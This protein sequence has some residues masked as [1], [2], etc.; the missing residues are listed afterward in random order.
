MSNKSTV[1]F[2]VMCSM[3][4]AAQAGFSTPENSVVKS[5][6]AGGEK[7]KSTNGGKAPATSA[8]PPA[9]ENGVKMGTQPRWK[10]YFISTNEYADYLHKDYAYVSEVK[11]PEELDTAVQN[12]FK[13]AYRN[14]Y[15]ALNLSTKDEDQIYDIVDGA[16]HDQELFNAFNEYMNMLNELEQMG[17]TINVHDVSF[18]KITVKDYTGDMLTVEAIWTVHGTLHHITHDH[19]QKNANCV[20]FKVQVSPENELKIKSVNVVSIDRFDLYQ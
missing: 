12:L 6:F 3:L 11:L 8:V 20:Q 2:C 13:R 10:S 5:E 18:R 16:Y 7:A 14:T 15:N 9:G 4:L 19:E 1:L 17:S